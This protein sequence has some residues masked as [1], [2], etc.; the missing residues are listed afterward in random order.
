MLFVLPLESVD[1]GLEYIRLDCIRC[2]FV[3]VC[4]NMIEHFW[5]QFL[6]KNTIFKF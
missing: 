6:N 4:Q 3:Q 1:F 5:A 2:K